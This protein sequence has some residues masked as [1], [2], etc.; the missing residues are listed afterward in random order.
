MTTQETSL[1]QAFQDHLDAGGSQD[2][3]PLYRRLRETQPV[4]RTPAGFWFV[5]SYELASRYYQLDRDRDSAWTKD[6]KRANQ[7]A[8]MGTL[9]TGAGMSAAFF[10]SEIHH[11]DGDD[12]ARLRRLMN[13]PFG[14]KAVAAL[15]P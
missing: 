1:E 11:R 3:H 15:R 8:D 2:P 9:T 5:T 7:S 13:K 12:H 6:A 10:A 4:F 14:P